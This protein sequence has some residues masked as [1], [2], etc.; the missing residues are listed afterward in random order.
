MQFGH[1]S[2]PRCGGKLSPSRAITRR[3]A[4][5]APTLPL[6]WVQRGDNGIV[7]LTGA[8]ARE[9]VLADFQ[10]AA[11]AVFQTLNAS[12]R[13][14]LNMDLLSKCDLNRSPQHKR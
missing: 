12:V 4:A 1:V 13:N 8:R 14:P 11:V 9:P 10:A 3:T 6:M 5:L 7:T 2:P